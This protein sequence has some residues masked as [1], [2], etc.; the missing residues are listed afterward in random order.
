MTGE[1]TQYLA[2]AKESLDQMRYLVD[3]LTDVARLETGKIAVE[4]QPRD[5]GPVV[6]RGVE[7]MQALAKAKGIGLT[8]AVEPGLPEVLIDERRL[9]QVLRNLL[10]NALKFTA[11]AGRVEVSVS[12]RCMIGACE[13]SSPPS[14]PCNQLLS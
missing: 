9:A 4:L 2:L 1:Q 14:S 13:V 5:L 7:G 3:D 11:E 6:A 10:S 8:L 12:S